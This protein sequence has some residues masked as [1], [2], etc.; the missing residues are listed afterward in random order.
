MVVFFFPDSEVLPCHI[1]LYMFSRVMGQKEFWT[2]A[3]DFLYM[4]F[5]YVCYARRLEVT[6]FGHL[7]LFVRPYIRVLYEYFV[8]LYMWEK[9]ERELFWGSNLKK[10][11]LI[12]FY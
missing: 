10:N 4:T 7:P 6:L 2:H 11:W 5:P 3:D 12:K 8:S 1:S 9:C